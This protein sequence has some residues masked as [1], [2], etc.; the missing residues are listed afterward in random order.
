MA[1]RRKVYDDDDGRTIAD[2]SGVERQSLLLP[3]SARSVQPESRRQDSEEPMG[4]ER[5]WKEEE[6][7]SREE[8]RWYKLGALKAGLLIALAFI[9]GLGLLILILILVWG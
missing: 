5:P 4:E 9:V 7:V 6:K 3:R 1:R 8:R 2:M